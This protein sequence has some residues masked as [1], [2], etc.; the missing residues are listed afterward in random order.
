MLLRKYYNHFVSCTF[1]NK[2]NGDSA[3]NIIMFLIFIDY[4]IHTGVETV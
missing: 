4:L 3:T 1:S 2:Q